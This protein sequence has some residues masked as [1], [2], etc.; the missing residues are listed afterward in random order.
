VLELYLFG[1]GVIFA[2]FLPSV[3]TPTVLILLSTRAVGLFVSTEL[4]IKNFL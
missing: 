2:L 1:L 4:N 3:C